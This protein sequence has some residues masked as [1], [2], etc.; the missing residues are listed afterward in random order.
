MAEVRRLCRICAKKEVD[1]NLLPIFG[2]TC[3]TAS[4]IFLICQVQ[5]I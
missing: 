3:S 1:G 4:D 5:V 2:G